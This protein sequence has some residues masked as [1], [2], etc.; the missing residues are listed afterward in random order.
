MRYSFVVALLV[1]FVW[2]GAGW[3]AD[4][5]KFEVGKA[6]VWAI[7]DSISER[8]MSVFPGVDQE[9]ISRYAPSGKS[10]SST[11]TF[12]VKTGESNET[13]LIDTGM[14]APSG[15]RASQLIPGL[16]EAGVAPEDVTLILI[17][18]MH[19]DHIGGLVRDGAKAFPSAR[20][21][22]PRIE[23]DFWLDEK[24]VELFT[25]RKANFEMARDIFG[26]YGPSSQTFEFGDVVTPGIQAVDARGHTPGQA[27]FLLES[28]GKKLLFWADIVHAAALQFPRPDLNPQYDM[29]PAEAGA[30]RLR[31]M[32][33]AA[34]EKLPVAGSHLPFPSV[35]EVAK[36]AAGGYTY[37]SY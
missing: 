16:K 3:A 14:G 19:G 37:T 26:L 17:T 9:V 18:H 13:I 6:T 1:C 24:S 5:A 33:K 25:A 10:P 11:M 32:E 34:T 7:A 30:A 12:L 2:S 29:D 35:G 36:D 23:L 8:E 22:S 28:E 27:A 20:V 21:L 31:F 4:V 15:D